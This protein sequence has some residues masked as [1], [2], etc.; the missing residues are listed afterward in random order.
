M[1]I[2]LTK[3]RIGIARYIT[4]SNMENFVLL[5]FP[6]SILKQFPEASQL[7]SRLRNYFFPVHHL[8]TILFS[9]FPLIFT[10]NFN[11]SDIKKNLKY[12]I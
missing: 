2:L 8:S 7:F 4:T 3:Y 9:D 12:M 6:N 1:L 11:Y 10:K 5:C